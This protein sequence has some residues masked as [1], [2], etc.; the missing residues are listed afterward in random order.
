MKSNT[1]SGNFSSLGYFSILNGC[2]FSKKLNFSLIQYLKRMRFQSKAQFWPDSEFEPNSVSQNSHFEPKI[3]VLGHS[4]RRWGRRQSRSGEPCLCL[5][6]NFERI[7]PRLSVW[8]M[9]FYLIQNPRL[10]PRPLSNIN[11]NY[12]LDWVLDLSES[13]VWSWVKIQD[14]IQDHDSKIGPWIPESE[15]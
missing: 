7:A 3:A 2:G 1:V 10:N 4:P 11:F 9:H 5:T 14:L 13:W 15:F 8:A 12:V 6:E